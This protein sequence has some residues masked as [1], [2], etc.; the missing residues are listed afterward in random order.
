MKYIKLSVVTRMIP[1][2]VV[3][4]V[5]SQPNEGEGQ[6]KFSFTGKKWQ[7]EKFMVAPAIDW[8]LDGTPD[9]DIFPLL[10][11]CDRDDLL[12]FR[13]DQ[14]MIRFSGAEKCDE[15]EEP[16]KED[17]TWKYNERTG[18]LTM[19]GDNKVEESKVL[20]SSAKRLTLKHVFKSTRGTEHALTATYVVR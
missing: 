8:D 17:G 7:M 16:A 18:M 4:S 19:A 5:N 14:K 15:D 11:P 2:L 3:C 1:V 20:E 13:E 6:G 9:T 12:L 10:E